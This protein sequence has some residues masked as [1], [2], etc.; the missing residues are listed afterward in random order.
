MNQLTKTA[1]TDEST[2]QNSQIKQFDSPKLAKLDI[3]VY[4]LTESDILPS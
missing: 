4:Q 1:K 2:Y 3:S